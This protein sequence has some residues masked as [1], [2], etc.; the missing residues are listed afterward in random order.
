MT[1]EVA[2]RRRPDPRLYY[3]LFAAAAAIAVTAEVSTYYYGDIIPVGRLWPLVLV[4]LALALTL[5]GVRR[6]ALGPRPKPSDLS[7]RWMLTLGFVRV[8][9]GFAGIALAAI[10]VAITLIGSSLAKVTL[11]AFVNTVL[12]SVS[13]GLLSQIALAS[14][15]LLRRQY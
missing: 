4:A 13:I 12:V 14:R 5:G 7:D 1:N 9:F 3:F 2:L 8:A 10:A 15:Q 11:F 6:I